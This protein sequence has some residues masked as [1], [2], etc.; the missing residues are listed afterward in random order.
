M[1]MTSD[2]LQRWA[3]I[4]RWVGL[5]VTAVGLL[6]TFGSHFIA[7]RLLSVQ[8]SDKA[9]AQERMQASE[10]ELHAIKSR[11]GWR[12][13]PASFAEVLVGRTAGRAEI[14]FRD[15]DDEAY[16]FA[17]SISDALSYAG[18]TVASPVSQISK[19]ENTGLPFMLREAGMSVGDWSKVAV[20]TREPLVA[21][22]YDGLTPLDA[23]MNAFTKAGVPVLHLIPAESLRPMPGV[24]RI[25]VGA[26]L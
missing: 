13:L 16:A 15:G 8:Q 22:P 24:V 23:L 9:K 10:A 3:S 4:L 14:V 17:T 26:R 19:P 25:V 1:H 12:R 11:V 6:I 18:W 7:D 20:L 21:K 5:G 2:E